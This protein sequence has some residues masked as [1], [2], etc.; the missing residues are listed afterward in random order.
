MSY[1]SQV[2][3]FRVSDGGSDGA[4]IL[5]VKVWAIDDKNMFYVFYKKKI[6]NMFFYVFYFFYVF[7]IF[8]IFVIFWLIKHLH[9]N[10]M[11][12]LEPLYRFAVNGQPFL[13]VP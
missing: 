6:K 4:G 8:F 9:I 12:F 11:H 10:V 1:S 3:K 13:Y 5:E 7:F 2:L